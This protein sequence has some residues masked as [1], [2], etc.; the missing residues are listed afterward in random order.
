MGRDVV[1]VNH[2]PALAAA[3]STRHR[4]VLWVVPG[5]AGAKKIRRFSFR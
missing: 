2:S 3:C 1:V 5:M 4:L